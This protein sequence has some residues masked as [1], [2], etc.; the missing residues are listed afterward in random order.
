[1]KRISTKSV[2]TGLVFASAA[3]MAGGAA[4]QTAAPGKATS[5]EGARLFEP[6]RQV[7]QHPRCQNCHIPGDAPLQYD[8]GLVH[9]QRVGRGADGKGL[10]ALQCSACH[11]T[12]NA[13]AA[14]GPNAPPGAPNWHLPPADMKMVF[15]NL[16]A[17]ELCLTVKDRK[18]NGNKGMDEFVTHIAEDKLVDWGWHPGGNR[19]PVSISKEETVAAVKA[20]VAAGAPCP[21]T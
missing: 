7:L 9:A 12:G 19:K 8:A 2:A 4:A 21:S 10:P 20:W 14:L 15:I 5:A 17:R 13:P 6:I 1:M 16:S 11:Q 3:V 18:R